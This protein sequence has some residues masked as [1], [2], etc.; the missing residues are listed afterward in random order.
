VKV[1]FISFGVVLVDQLSKLFVKGFSIPFFNFNIHG[2]YQGERIPLIGNFFNITFVENPGIAFGIYFGDS[3]K[4]LISLFTLIASVGLAV[5]LYRSRNKIFSLRIAIALI[6]GGAIGNLIDRIFYGV[7]YGYGPLFHG[8]VVDFFNLKFF[9]FF[10]FDRLF[11]SYVFNFADL[12]VTSGVILLLFALNWQRN[13]E[14]EINPA[15]ENYLA[16]NK[17]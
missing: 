6:L 11:G 7:F 17:E 3:F 1:L 13:I 16:E 12:S 2:M 4:F 10:I 5:Y 15:V 9:N 8:K 14:N